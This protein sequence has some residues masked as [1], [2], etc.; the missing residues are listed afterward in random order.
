MT[1]IQ[2]PAL[3]NL[4]GCP[5]PVLFSADARTRT[6]SVA[7]RCERAHRYLRGVLGFNPNLRLLVLSPADWTD[8]TN[9]QPYGMPHFIGADTIVVGAETGDFFKSITL[10]LDKILTSAQR[11]EMEAVYGTGRRPAR[12]VSIRG[13][14]SRSRA[15]PP[16]SRTG[17]LRLFPAL[18]EGAFRQ[19]LPARLRRRSG[20]RAV[21]GIDNPSPT[22]VSAAGRAGA[23]PLAGGLREVARQRRSRELRMVSVQ[24]PC[25]G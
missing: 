1:T 18:A 12:H 19:P 25:C 22:D 7:A 13:S 3:Q 2:R 11:A 21:T 4:E 17:P 20:A 24:T 6:K 15:R 5:F 10:M 14:A 9:V 16:V 23:T 8:H